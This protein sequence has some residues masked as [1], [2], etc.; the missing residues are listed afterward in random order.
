MLLYLADKVILRIRPVV[1]GNGQFFEILSFYD[2]GWTIW[3]ESLNYKTRQKTVD[4]INQAVEMNPG[5]YI[6]DEGLDVLD[7]KPFI[8]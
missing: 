4:A 1:A 2:A 5:I 7:I 8:K 3:T 6:A